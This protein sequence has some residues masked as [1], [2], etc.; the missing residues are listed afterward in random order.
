M[1]LILRSLWLGQWL[2]LIGFVKL[3]GLL[4]VLIQISNFS[5]R[6]VQGLLI[7]LI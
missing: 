5:C 4:Q 7:N 3:M 6:E 2:F 1:V